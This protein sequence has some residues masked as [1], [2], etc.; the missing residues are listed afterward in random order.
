MLLQ[1]RRWLPQRRLVVVA[2]AGFAVISLL[3]RLQRLTNP[4]CMVTRFRLDAALYEP[5]SPRQPH[6]KGRT[7]LKGKR[8]PTL[9]KVLHDRKTIPGGPSYPFVGP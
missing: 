2:D 3:A 6:Q 5:T 7:P 9:E 1:G 8:L 4:I